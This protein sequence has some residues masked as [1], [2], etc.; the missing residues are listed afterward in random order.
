[1]ANEV[2]SLDT[3]SDKDDGIQEKRLKNAK[4][5]E[6]AIYLKNIKENPYLSVH[7]VTGYFIKSQ[8]FCSSLK[9]TSGASW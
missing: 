3:S 7:A 8:Q 4:K 2:L 1:M 5:K 6:K 9:G